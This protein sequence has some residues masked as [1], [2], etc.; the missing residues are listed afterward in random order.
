MKLIF[1]NWRKF[2][3]EEKEEEAN[4]KIGIKNSAVDVKL[5]SEMG[6]NILDDI[7]DMIKTSYKSM[8]GFPSLETSDG[9]FDA[10]KWLDASGDIDTTGITDAQW[11]AYIQAYEDNSAYLPLTDFDDSLGSVISDEIIADFVGT[12]VTGNTETNIT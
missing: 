3:K 10:D 2:L 12:M 5:S 9:T 6:D 8:G 11:Q 1:E 7:A 4:S